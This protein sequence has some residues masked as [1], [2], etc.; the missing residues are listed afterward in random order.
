MR[1]YEKDLTR[2][3]AV[4]LIVLFGI[5]SLFAD[6]NYEGG[7]SVV[8]QYLKLLGT[9]AFALGI[10]AGFGEFVGYALRLISGSIADRTKKYWTLI[11]LGYVVQLSALPLLA[12]VRG[13][14]L[15]V[16]FLFLERVGKA[17]RKPA[18]DAVIS[19]A[20]KKTGS[21]FGFGLHEA[22][23]QIGAFLGPA[24]FSLLLFAGPDAADLA[25]YRKGLLLLFIPA[26]LAVGITLVSRF[27]FPHPDRFE[28][29][30]AA[31]EISA[32]GYSKSYWI[33]VISAGLLAMGI[34]DFPL[35]GLHLK[36][37]GS[38]T[39]AAIPL[40][41]SG[42]MA[43]DAAAA[44]IFGKLYDRF[45]LKALAVLFIVEVF[46]AP[47]VFLGPFWAILLGMALWGI[48]VGTQESIL[49]AA[50]GDRVVPEK[51]ARAFGLFNTIFGLFWFAGSAIIG[52]LYDNFGPV[53]MVVFSVAVQAGAL[54]LFLKLA[55]NE[56]RT[57]IHSPS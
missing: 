9:S 42:A 5:V 34:T 36:N 10:A 46:T 15:A 24:L 22:M 20:A 47:L 17:I 57:T 23:D 32:K 16:A 35:I 13:W 27:I 39:E 55:L 37:T 14:E 38:F 28:L 33:I 51:R 25:G 4:L 19:F 53:P 31:P 12:F 21:G 52:L 29:K 41:Y 7:R 1:R 43:I 54:V 49:K 2:N 18:H 48:S 44:L 56:P 6:M 8:G 50:I 3:A 11:I 40:L 26:V 30:H 45:G